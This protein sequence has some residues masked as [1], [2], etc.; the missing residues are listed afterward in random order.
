MGY[1][2]WYCLLKELIGIGISFVSGRNNNSL[3]YRAIHTTE[4]SVMKE[5]YGLAAINNSSR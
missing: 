3:Y 4:A 5:C 2:F 1:L